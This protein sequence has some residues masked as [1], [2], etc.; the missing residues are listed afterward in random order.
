MK[1]K[2]LFI[3]IGSYCDGTLTNAVIKQLLQ[4]FDV[5]FITDKSS[6]IENAIIQPN[7]IYESPAFI[8]VEPVIGGADTATN[9]TNWLFSTPNQ[10]YQLFQMI[11]NIYHIIQKCKEKYKPKLILFHY[12]LLNIALIFENE[13]VPFG[14]V[15]YTPAY[16]NNTIPW[17]FDG[18]IRNRN[19]NLYSSS[20]NKEIIKQ[21]WK[22]IIS[23]TKLMTFLMQT[24]VNHQILLNR[25]KKLHF[26][27]CWD[28][29]MTKNIKPLVSKNNIHYV[30]SIYP[31]HIIK[32]IPLQ[33]IPKIPKYL[34]SFIQENKSKKRQMALISFGSFAKFIHLQVAFK[35]IISVLL[36]NNYSIII[37]KTWNVQNKIENQ[38]FLNQFSNNNIFVQ[39][40]FIPYESLI[41]H[42][43]LIVFTGS[44]CLQLIA[45]Q[46]MKDMIFFPLIT[47]QF[48]WAKNYEYF[49]KVPYVDIAEFHQKSIP[50]Q[51]QTALKKTTEMNQ[52]TQ[53]KNYQ[54]MVQKSM[55]E[56]IHKENLNSEIK[57]IL[58]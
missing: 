57:K 24:G 40:G 45:F 39:I 20:K 54:Y 44:L 31:N 10:V 21:S 18:N 46:T 38:K 11:N 36:E 32:K 33:K 13:S 48:F 58:K 35:D 51:L 30:G 55:K 4:K 27:L 28:K 50:L 8:T 22:T 43:D 47:E 37:H 14:L 34:P 2:I 19:F 53:L 29:N 1:E 26:F 23:R 15:Y 7:E 42:I 17:I 49:T 52:N 3:N 25:L 5:K 16:L 9:L 41:P 12:S 6:I 56:N